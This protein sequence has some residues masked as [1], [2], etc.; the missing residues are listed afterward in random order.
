MKNN[1]VEEIKARIN[2]YEIISKYVTLEKS[3]DKYKGLCPFHQENTPSFYLEPDNG[4]YYCFGCQAGGDVIKFLME[5]EGWTFV[6]TMRY[7]GQEVGIS[8]NQ[9]NKTNYTEK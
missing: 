2:P 9:T 1:N 6:E 4:L 5:L 3:G 7:L 8:F